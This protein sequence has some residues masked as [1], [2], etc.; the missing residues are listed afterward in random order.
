MRH[1]R[2]FHIYDDNT[3]YL[4]PGGFININVPFDPEDPA[5]FD[6]TEFSQFIDSAFVEFAKKD[7]KILSSI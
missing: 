4:R 1:N 5:T 7:S 3:A 2:E 6:N